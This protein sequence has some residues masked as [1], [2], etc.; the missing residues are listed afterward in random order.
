MRT[1]FVSYDHDD[2]S[3]VYSLKG[4]RCNPNNPVKFIDGSLLY[5]VYN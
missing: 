4:I 5:P 3:Y 1:V 2:Q